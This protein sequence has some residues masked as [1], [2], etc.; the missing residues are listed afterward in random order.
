MWVLG[1]RR[2]RL[3]EL[4][5][6]RLE[7]ATAGEVW[8]L[9]SEGVGWRI[10]DLECGELARLR[11]HFYRTLRE[12]MVVTEGVAEEEVHGAEGEEGALQWWWRYHVQPKWTWRNR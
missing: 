9:D 3:T 6:A 12:C 4:E 2:R 11:Q 1:R 10:P 7:Q 5:L 8:E